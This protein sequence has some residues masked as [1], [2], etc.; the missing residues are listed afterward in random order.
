MRRSPPAL[1][2]TAVLVLLG[3]SLIVP[4]MMLERATASA[5]PPYSGPQASPVPTSSTAFIDSGEPASTDADAP[6]VAD[7]AP[8]RLDLR[9][10]EISRPLARYRVDHTGSLYEEHSPHTEVPRL[11]QPVM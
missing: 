6:P 10:N 1:W 8:R 2:L 9:G 7:H 11:T 3:I 4:G 5:P